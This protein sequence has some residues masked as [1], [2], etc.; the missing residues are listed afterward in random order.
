MKEYE[1]DP[2][3]AN[4]SATKG[5][6]IHGKPFELN[7]SYSWDP[8]EIG[9]IEYSIKEYVWQDKTYGEELCHS[10]NPVCNVVFNR[11][12]LHKIVLTVRDAGD[13]VEEGDDEIDISSDRDEIKIIVIE[14]PE[15]APA[16]TPEP[17]EPEPTPTQVIIPTPE[18]TPTP[19]EKPATTFLEKQK[20]FFW[21]IV[22]TIKALIG[23]NP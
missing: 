1:N 11:T 13:R 5:T 3:I 9:G 7:G 14:P 2:P 21:E 8:D 6:A 15:P 4:A 17:P 10:K 19:T 23:L 18:P 16:I 20:S 22:E 12:G